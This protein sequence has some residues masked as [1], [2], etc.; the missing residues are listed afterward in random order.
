[1][2]RVI[3]LL[4]FLLLL[5]N[6]A[7]AQTA[8]VTRNVNLRPDASTNGAPLAKLTAGAQVELLE[9]TGTNGFFHVKTADGTE[10]WAWGQTST[11]KPT[12]PRTECMWVR[13]AFIPMRA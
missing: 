3:A 10:G 13:Q 12:K 6:L 2:K 9:P 11:F 4:V 8:V 5:G 1:M 7:A